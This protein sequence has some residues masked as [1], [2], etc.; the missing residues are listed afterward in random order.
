MSIP[1]I[2]IPR[3]R[4]GEQTGFYDGGL[5]EKTPLISPMA[6]HNRRYPDRKLLLIGTHFGREVKQDGARGFIMRFLVTINAL[7]NLVWEYQMREVREAPNVDLIILN[8]RIG[9]PALFDFTRVER[10]HLHAR[11][12]LADTL[13]DAKIALAFGIR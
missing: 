11:E 9:D 7:E 8:P 5:V 3:E 6:E 10:N 12:V 1:G 13:Q 4:D 2:V